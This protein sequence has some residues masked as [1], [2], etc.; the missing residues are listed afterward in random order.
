MS[1]KG[2]N[3]EAARARQEEQE[4]QQRIR[5]GTS[6]VGG[7]FDKQ[8]NS[9]FFNRQQGNYLNYATPQLDDQHRDAQ[10]EL[11]YA[12]ARAG[13]L[14]SSSRADLGGELQKKYGIARQKIADDALAYKNKSRTSVEDARANLIA[15]LNNTGDAEGAAQA[16]IRR[17]EALSQPA[18][19]SP[20][21]QMFQ[22][23]TAS[24]GSNAAAERSYAA[25]A[26]R[27][28]RG[29]RWFGPHSGSVATT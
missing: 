24:L 25:G 17:S 13:T 7:I 26:P 11:T 1:K 14:E 10:K 19:Y 5:S 8:F 23:F 28:P 27:L 29:T 21:S 9:D 2:G 18:A 6:R 4:R 3:D 22:D 12:L 16:A 20:L 15:M